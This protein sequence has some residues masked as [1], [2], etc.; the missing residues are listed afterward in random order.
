MPYVARNTAPFSKFRLLL[1]GLSQSGKTTSL[2]TFVYGPYDYHDSTEQAQA[3]DYAGDKTMVI[4]ECPGETGHR[5][6]PID[7][8]HIH[9]YYPETEGEDVTSAKWSTEAIKQFDALY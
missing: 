8:P 1:S 2:S 5:S 6:L 7:T 3:E 4:I 9:S